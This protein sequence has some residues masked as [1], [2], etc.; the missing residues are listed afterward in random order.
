MNT[1]RIIGGE[2]RRRVLR[3]PDSPGL[4]PTPDRV[5]ETLFNWLG[6]D[7][8]GLSCLDLFAGSGALGFEA[9]SRG[10]AR[11][12]LVDSSPKVVAALELNARTLGM[13][14]RLEIVR[15][16][17]VRFAASARSRFDVLFLDPPFNEGWIE[18][19]ATN[20]PAILAADGV[21]YVEAERALDGCGDRRT[22]RRGRAGQVYYHLMRRGEADGAE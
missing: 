5:R 4:R 13:A 8:S 9:A 21:I 16:D 3:F 2:W 20:V 17:A 14:G 12:T 6:N 11:V 15:S 18:R 19:L 7:L 10:A 1:V 22:V